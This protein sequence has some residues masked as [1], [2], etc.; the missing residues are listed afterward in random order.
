MGLIATPSNQKTNPIN[1]KKLLVALI[2][3]LSFSLS[4]QAQNIQLYKSLVQQAK[5]FYANGEY[6]K[7]GMTYANAFIAVKGTGT[8]D[9]RYASAQAWARAG[10][11]EKAFVDLFR[12]GKSGRFT[13]VEMLKSDEALKS[14]HSNSKWEELCTLVQSHKN[15]TEADLIQPAAQTLDKIYRHNKTRLNKIKKLG[16]AHGWDS[17]EVYAEFDVISHQ[18]SLHALEVANILDEHGWQGPKYFGRT[19]TG[20]IIQTLRL[21]NLETQEKYLPLM[22]KAVDIKL[23]KT[24]DLIRMEDRV[25]IAKYKKQIYGSQIGYD[26]DNERYYVIPVDNPDSV[27]ER[28]ASLGIAPMSQ[29]VK[30][31]KIDWNLKKYKKELPELEKIMDK[32]YVYYSKRKR[33]ARGAEFLMGKY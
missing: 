21:A 10:D 28:R 13:K 30:R 8:V 29:Y 20:A 7:A 17:D 23:V 12:I 1:M 14:L 22:R 25:S 31:W 32:E 27:D 18:D 6:D 19:G 4:T 11:Q 26:Y 5:E 2:T 24:S 9:D 3:C 16:D 33:S 15:T